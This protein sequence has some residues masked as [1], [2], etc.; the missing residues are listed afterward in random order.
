MLALTWTVT[1]IVGAIG[2][3]TLAGEYPTKAECEHAG[4]AYLISHDWDLQQD[5]YYCV[6]GRP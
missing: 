6:E 4:E 2:G 1:F 3:T 5:T